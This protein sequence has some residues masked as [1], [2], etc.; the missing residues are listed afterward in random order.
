MILLEKIRLCAEIYLG[1]AFLLTS[2][3]YL[4]YTTGR[5]IIGAFF[6]IRLEDVNS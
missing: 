6:F 2:L 1:Y 5:W 3:F 4:H